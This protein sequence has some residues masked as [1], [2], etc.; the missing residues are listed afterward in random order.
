MEHLSCLLAFRFGLL[1]GF[2]IFIF[3]ITGRKSTLLGMQKRQREAAL[4]HI[5]SIDERKYH[6]FNLWVK[7]GMIRNSLE[8][9]L[10]IEAQTYI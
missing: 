8:G 2:A 6:L 5:Y 1:Q 3:G 4:Y 7:N 10:M 9:D